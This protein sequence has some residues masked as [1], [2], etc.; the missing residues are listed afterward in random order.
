MTNEL[1]HLRAFRAAAA[2][3]DADARATARARLLEAIAAAAP[4]TAAPAAGRRPRRRRLPLPRG[5]LGLRPL[6]APVAALAAIALLAIVLLG[7]AGKESAPPV[8]AS[9]AELLDEAAR[10]AAVQPYTP[11]AD[12]QY[13]YVRSEGD[14]QRSSFSGWRT[15]RQ[16]FMAVTLP[17]TRETWWGTSG[18]G[19]ERVELGA[20]PISFPNPY[21]RRAWLARHRDWAGDV[22]DQPRGA[23]A[24]PSAFSIGPVTTAALEALPT[25]PDALRARFLG[26]I[27]RAFAQA[28]RPVRGA[29]RELRWAVISLLEQTAAPT[30]P[31]LQA[32]LLRLLGQ[33]PGVEPR[34][35]TTDAVGRRGFVVATTYL[36]LAQRHELV[37]D[38][39][40]GALLETRDVTTRASSLYPGMNTAETRQAAGTTIRATRVESAIVGSIRARP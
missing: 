4:A 6:V 35:T 7:G 14:G 30:P 13:W 22:T 11:L 16:A 24:R 12:G 31:A 3:P 23:N 27:E 2:A 32:A 37:I 9:A 39:A 21:A 33:L 20:K 15:P 18:R 5:R 19:R 29:Q 34:G 40:T 36:E 25:D 26:S 17:E 28:G 10:G 38:P 1:D 8:P